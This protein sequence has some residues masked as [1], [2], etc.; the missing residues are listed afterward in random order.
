MNSRR[1]TGQAPQAEGLTLPCCGPHCASRQI[2]TAA[3]VVLFDHQIGAAKQRKRYRKAEGLCG[4]QVND[5]LD[6]GGLLNWKI[7]WLFPLRIR[8][9]YPPIKR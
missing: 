6:L 3:K 2:L 1:L 7:G 4:F 9:A 5:Q 8:L